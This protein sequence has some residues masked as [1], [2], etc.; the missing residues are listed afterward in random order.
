MDGHK[1]IFPRHHRVSGHRLSASLRWRRFLP[2]RPLVRLVRMTIGRRVPGEALGKAGAATSGNVYRVV[3]PLPLFDHHAACPDCP[4]RK[5]QS[6]TL[7]KAKNRAPYPA[8][9]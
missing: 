5:P 8:R 9:R 4:P 3:H 6:G 2:L 1:L 7:R